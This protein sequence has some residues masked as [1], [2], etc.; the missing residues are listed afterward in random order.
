MDCNKTGG[1]IFRP[2]TVKRILVALV[3]A[4]LTVAFFGA[5]QQNKTFADTPV[6]ALGS[7]TANDPQAT[8]DVMGKN[9]GIV[10]IICNAPAKLG[11]SDSQITTIKTFVTSDANPTVLLN[12]IGE[13]DISTPFK[14]FTVKDYKDKDI[15]AG[16]QGV[17]AALNYINDKAGNNLLHRYWA[18]ES[19]D[20]VNTALKGPLPISINRGDNN[21]T[22]TAT[23]DLP[24]CSDRQALANSHDPDLTI[25]DADN[26]WR[27]VITSDSNQNYYQRP[28]PGSIVENI[29]IDALQVANDRNLAVSGAIANMLELYR[30]VTPLETGNGVLGLSAPKT[31][32]ISN[33]AEVMAAKAAQAASQTANPDGKVSSVPIPD[34]VYANIQNNT[35]RA[36]LAININENVARQAN[37]QAIGLNLSL[38]TGG[39]S[40]NAGRIDPSFDVPTSRTFQINMDNFANEFMDIGDHTITADLV[41]A[42][43]QVLS[44][45][46]QTIRVVAIAKPSVSFE[47]CVDDQNSDLCLTHIDPIV[48]SGSTTS[49]TTGGGTTLRSSNNNSSGFFALD[50]SGGSYLNSVV[51]NVIQPNTAYYAN[52]SAAGSND[53]GAAYCRASSSTVDCTQVCISSRDCVYF[54]VLGVDNIITDTTVRENLTNIGSVNVLSSNRIRLPAILDPAQMTADIYDGNGERI[55]ENYQVWDGLKQVYQFIAGQAASDLNENNQFAANRSA[56]EI[57]RRL[58]INL[59][60]Y[61]RTNPDSRSGDFVVFD[62]SKHLKTD[63]ERKTLQNAD[64]SFAGLDGDELILAPA[65]NYGQYLGNPGETNKINGLNRPMWQNLR[66]IYQAIESSAQRRAVDSSQEGY[67][68][69]NQAR[70]SKEAI[71]LR[72]AD[73][74]SRP[75]SQVYERVNNDFVVY[76]I[77]SYGFTQEDIDKIGGMDQFDTDIRNFF[78]GDKAKLPARIKAGQIYQVDKG[79][80]PLVVSIATKI[81]DVYTVVYNNA[82]NETDKSDATASIDTIKIDIIDQYVTSGGCT[83]ETIWSSFGDNFIVCNIDRQLGSNYHDQIRGWIRTGGI[84]AAE[85]NELILPKV[86]KSEDIGQV[87]HS[88]RDNMQAWEGVKK[89]YQ[90]IKD[91][92]TDLDIKAYCQQAIDVIDTALKTEIPFEVATVGS[93]IILVAYNPL[94]ICNGLGPN[95]D[96]DITVSDNGGGSKSCIIDGRSDFKAAR[97]DSAADRLLSEAYDKANELQLSDDARLINQLH[98]VYLSAARTDA[99]NEA[100]TVTAPDQLTLTPMYASLQD[101]SLTVFDGFPDNVVRL[102]IAIKPD[103]LLSQYNPANE[104]ITMVASVQTGNNMDDIYLD[105]LDNLT[106]NGKE[107]DWKVNSTEP[108]SLEPGSH[109]FTFNFYKHGKGE[110]WENGTVVSTLSKPFTI[111]QPSAPVDDSSQGGDTRCPA[112]RVKASSPVH[113]SDGAVRIETTFTMPNGGQLMANEQMLYAL[114]ISTDNSEN[115][116]VQQDL[117][118]DKVL[119]PFNTPL[120]GQQVQRKYDWNISNLDP[121]KYLV[122]IKTFRY[123]GADDLCNPDP[124]SQISITID[125]ASSPGQGGCTVRP[126]GARDCGSSGNNSARDIIAGLSEYSYKLISRILGTA[127]MKWYYWL[128]SVLAVVGIIVGGYQIMTAGGNS[129]QVDKGKKT[130]TYTIIGIVI[131]VLFIVITTAVVNDI[132]KLIR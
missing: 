75:K 24:A 36:G 99:S 127:A 16:W 84:V 93:E 80:S 113:V 48:A 58:D 129:Q 120:T 21:I 71:D 51:N 43:G 67:N 15:I 60:S 47:T 96:A 95:D 20:K 46:S 28:R 69:M 4:V 34:F 105:I 41:T 26:S 73:Y 88:N 2:K 5:G 33:Y 126:D 130:I 132:N 103:A 63:S 45:A 100:I 125:S 128:L 1:F 83:N 118:N 98:S 76:N 29:L 64:L 114:Y 101:N 57:T 119:A 27:C 54:V 124:K 39:V 40:Q 9:D 13:M 61:G 55:E 32:V 91:N 77:A 37:R 112:I 90:L 3:S 106:G 31:L 35:F 108:A 62:I 116:L 110:F 70:L 7:C 107:I 22:L 94:E 102:E 122:R 123:Q 109:A 44:T 65:F 92:S 79:L 72:L 8:Y 87:D 59:A 131:G 97:R 66:D 50:Y 10:F 6:R 12:D 121:G 49:V 78:T 14:D 53:N 81:R 42:G 23:P 19:A 82:Q 86:L 115:N 74:D 111:V 25:E 30:A 56:E 18:I 104:S 11:L 85:N 52:A 17:I 38:N 68:D 89:A 117:G